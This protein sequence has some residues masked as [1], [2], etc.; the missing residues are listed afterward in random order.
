MQYCSFNPWSAVAK[1]LAAHGTESDPDVE[2]T[3]A[4]SVGQWGY[5]MAHLLEL[6]M[7]PC[8]A[9]LCFALPFSHATGLRLSELVDATIGRI[10]TMPLLCM[11]FARNAL[12]CPAL[13][14]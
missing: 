10:Y 3:R 1:S 13:P 6:P 8:T 7:I 14:P 9:R 5:M 4:L 2:F 11:Q 12:A